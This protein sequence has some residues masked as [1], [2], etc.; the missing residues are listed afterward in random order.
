M[1]DEQKIRKEY[2]PRQGILTKHQQNPYKNGTGKQA[3]S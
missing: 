3:K 1:K 2:K